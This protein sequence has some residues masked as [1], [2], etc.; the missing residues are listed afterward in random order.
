MV[1]CVYIDRTAIVV[2]QRNEAQP[3]SRGE[4]ANLSSRVLGLDSERSGID[5]SKGI[6]KEGYNLDLWMVVEP[7]A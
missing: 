7:L 4:M 6:L 3:G 1:L 2:V 5:E